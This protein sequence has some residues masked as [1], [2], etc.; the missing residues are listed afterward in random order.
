M[1]PWLFLNSGPGEPAFNMALD[2]ALLEAMPRLQEP[3]LRCYAWTV[4][5]ATFG[6]FQRMADVETFTALRPLIRRPTGGGVVP[7]DRDW[8]Y[9]LFFPPGHEWYHLK[10]IDSYRQ[11]HAWLADAFGW[12]GVHAELAPAALKTGPGQCFAGHE[13]YD[14]LW[15]GRK[16][17][18]AAQR[19][20]REGLL[21][22]GSVQPLQTALSR[23]AWEQALR[24]VQARALS[25][26]WRE[27]LPD[28][29][30]LERAKELA[31]TRYSQQAYNWKR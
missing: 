29:E 1:Q 13:Q 12:L 30:L 24:E 9:S 22:Q 20:T 31:R 4:P 17:A 26:E 2:H 18:G 28:F 5:A 16:L 19:R 15:R 3:V 10:A 21:I 6:Y 14:L 8:T 27:L 23:E 7:H 25:V 11:V